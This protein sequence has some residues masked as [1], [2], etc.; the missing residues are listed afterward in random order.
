M[1]SFITYLEEAKAPKY[2]NN[3]DKKTVI[4]KEIDIIDNGETGS[5][6]LFYGAYKSGS[7]K[8]KI[9]GYITSH[10]LGIELITRKSYTSAEELKDDADFIE[11]S[12]VKYDDLIK[13]FK[14]I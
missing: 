13:T 8:G 9:G 10:D 7:N 3:F 1:K 14:R 11:S 6:S 5:A 4:T 2:V 12:N